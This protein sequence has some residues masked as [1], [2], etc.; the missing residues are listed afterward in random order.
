MLP[1]P[2]FARLALR[3]LEPL[4]ITRLAHHTIIA[5]HWG[6]STELS[7]FWKPLPAVF[8]L[9][10]LVRI[11]LQDEQMSLHTSGVLNSFS[12]LNQRR[13]AYTCDVVCVWEKDMRQR[14]KKKQRDNER[15]G[16]ISGQTDHVLPSQTCE[17]WV[18]K[19]FVAFSVGNLWHAHDGCASGSLQFFW[20]QS[21]EAL[22]NFPC[23][24]KRRDISRR[25]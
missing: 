19:S 25:S 5:L 7:E 24:R 22:A 3:D 15:N 13:Q 16:E 1:F 10:G 17:S 8:T 9:K 11:S 20:G 4:L 14:E 12:C 23:F 18:M 2:V 21:T 6:M